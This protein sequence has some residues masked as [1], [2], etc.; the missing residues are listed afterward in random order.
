MPRGTLPTPQRNAC[1]LDDEDVT[2]VSNA[3]REMLLIGR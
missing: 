3:A 2:S 1:K